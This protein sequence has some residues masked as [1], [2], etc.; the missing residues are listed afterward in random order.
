MCLYVHREEGKKAQ[1]SFRFLFVC[2]EKENNL[3]KGLIEFNET[4]VPIQ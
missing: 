2:G 3:D 4:S 1:Q